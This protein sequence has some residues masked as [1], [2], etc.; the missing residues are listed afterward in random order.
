MGK[1]KARARE[2]P[3]FGNDQEAAASGLQIRY[4]PQTARTKPA[5]TSEHT[6]RARSCCAMCGLKTARAM[7]EAV[8]APDAIAIAPPIIF[9]KRMR[10]P[11]SMANEQFIGRMNNLRPRRPDVKAKPPFRAAVLCK[12]FDSYQA[13]CAKALLA[14][15]MRCISSFFLIAVPSFFAASR[16]SLASFSAIGFPLPARAALMSQRYASATRRC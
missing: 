10:P 1:K 3:D 8:P 6:A 7:P 9:L 11:K 5:M 16:I 2:R 14:S 13:K 12:I 4:P 15:A